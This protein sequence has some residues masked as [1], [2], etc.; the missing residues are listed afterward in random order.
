MERNHRYFS[1]ASGIA[2]SFAAVASA[3]GSEAK[4]KNTEPTPNSTSAS[5]LEQHLATRQAGNIES[6]TITEKR[7]EE[8]IEFMKCSSIEPLELFAEKLMQL[9]SGG[10]LVLDNFS[11][12]DGVATGEIASI[13][14]YGGFPTP[15]DSSYRMTIDLNENGMS[16]ADY[17]IF[18]YKETLVMTTLNEQI[19]R[20]PN[21]AT[22]IASSEDRTSIECLAWINTIKNVGIPLKGKVEIQIIKD[23]IAAYERH[24]PEGIIDCI[25]SAD[26]N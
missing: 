7:L 15:N 21:A 18:L 1:A 8:T 16:Y 22:K 10:Y 25:A 5:C 9:N 11:R 17:A 3:C 12:P 14:F 23:S 20:A 6:K 13:T 24:D 19:R 26:L 2:L 4:P